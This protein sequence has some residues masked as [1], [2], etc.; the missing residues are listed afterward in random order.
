MRKDDF[1]LFESYNVICLASPVLANLVVDAVTHPFS[2]AVRADLNA[3]AR[4]MMESLLTMSETVALYNNLQLQNI[5]KVSAILERGVIAHEIQHPTP[6]CCFPM[7]RKLTPNRN[8]KF[9][10]MM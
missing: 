3:Q 4:V 6:T 7:M 1:E 8:W 2:A 10:P 5:L 9:T